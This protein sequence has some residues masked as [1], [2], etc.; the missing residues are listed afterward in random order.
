MEHLIA[1]LVGI[2]FTLIMIIRI[3]RE[4]EKTGKRT[5]KDIQAVITI[6]TTGSGYLLTL[7]VFMVVRMM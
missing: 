2:V 7:L 5:P 6:C 3:Y 4:D 1:C